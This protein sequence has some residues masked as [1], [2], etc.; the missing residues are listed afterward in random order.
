MPLG[1]IIYAGS[2]FLLPV[3]LLL[4]FAGGFHMPSYNRLLIASSKGGVG[5]ST[6]AIGLAASYALMGK[7]VLLT[8]LDCTSRSLDL[9]VGCDSAVFDFA[10]L[11]DETKSAGDAAVSGIGGI[12]GLSLITACTPDRLRDTASA[13]GISKKELVRTVLKRIFDDP[14]YDIVICDT[15]GGTELAE[16]AADMFGMVIIT[17]EQS[18][19]SVRAAEFAAQKL[20]EH[21][22]GAMRLVICAFDLM[23]VKREKRAGMIEMIDASSLQC[24]GVVPYDKALQKLQDNGCIPGR[25]TIAMKAY[26]NI[27]RRIAGFDVPLFDGM[28]KY[29]RQRKSAF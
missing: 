5:K 25:K 11:A 26:A 14:A 28:G 19:T 8:D 9:L 12:A 13:K 3:L 17:S 10:D 15:G 21:G 22:A 18:Q 27:A 24:A 1:V 16:A 20:S 29:H 23:A 2:Y 6:T 7:R 4:L